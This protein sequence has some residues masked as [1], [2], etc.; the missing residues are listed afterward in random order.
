M[1]AV[2]FNPRVKVRQDGVDIDSESLND[3]QRTSLDLTGFGGGMAGDPTA[4]VI[5]GAVVAVLIGLAAVVTWILALVKMGHCNG[6][7]TPYF[8]ATLLLFVLLPGP[9]SFAAFIMA[10]VALV[11]LKPGKTALGMTCPAR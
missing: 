4:G 5:A 3:I 11:L 8:W 9:G 7:K 6:T 10:I 1:S 2:Q